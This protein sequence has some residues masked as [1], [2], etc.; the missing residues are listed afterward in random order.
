[1]QYVEIP[2]SETRILVV[3]I[4]ENSILL[5]PIRNAV[6][7]SVKTSRSKFTLKATNDDISKTI[8]SLVGPCDLLS[9]FIGSGAPEQQ[10]PGG[11]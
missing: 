7:Y 9:G 2:Y 8:L 4:H 1:M 6:E 3:P 5:S 10:S 11:V